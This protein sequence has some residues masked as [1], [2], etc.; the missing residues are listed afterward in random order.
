MARSILLILAMLL[1]S[2]SVS[3]D[4]WIP[5]KY[6]VCKSAVYW[7]ALWKSG[8]RSEK[9][10]ATPEVGGVPGD[11]DTEALVFALEVQVLNLQRFEL[12]G[13][14][15]RNFSSRVGK[16]WNGSKPNKPLGWPKELTW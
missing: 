14:K 5:P 10:N 1:V 8:K 15:S 16:C 7:S 6:W 13:A 9:W 2:Q 12:A 3:A 4:D 11:S